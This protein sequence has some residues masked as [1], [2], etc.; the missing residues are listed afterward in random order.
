MSENGE[1]PS[2]ARPNLSIDGKAR[3]AMAGLFA[4]AGHKEAALLATRRGPVFTV[5]QRVEGF[6]VDME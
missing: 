2:L 5:Q 3:S 1:R 6:V 4:F